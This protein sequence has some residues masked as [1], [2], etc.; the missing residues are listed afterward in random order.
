MPAEEFLACRGNPSV[1]IEMLFPTWIY[2]WTENKR[3]QVDTLV[4]ASSRLKI[5]NAARH[6]SIQGTCPRDTIS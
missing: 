5:S 1:D 4:S 3:A 6:T 2:E